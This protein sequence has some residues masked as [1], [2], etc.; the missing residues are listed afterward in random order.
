M[1]ETIGQV[2]QCVCHSSVVGTDLGDDV[3]NLV[4]VAEDSSVL[5]VG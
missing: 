3:E 5:Q 4:Y 2:R 1:L